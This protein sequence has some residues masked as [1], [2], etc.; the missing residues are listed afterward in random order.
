MKVSTLL[1]V[2]VLIIAAYTIIPISGKPMLIFFFN[3]LWIVDSELSIIVYIFFSGFLVID[4]YLIT[5]IELH[6]G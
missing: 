4:D 2:T 6:L 5:F 3:G 1:F